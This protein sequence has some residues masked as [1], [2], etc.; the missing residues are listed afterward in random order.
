MQ[1]FESHKDEALSATSMS[2]QEPSL[3]GV[4]RARSGCRV[5][6]RL[7]GAAQELGARDS[8][9]LGSGT[10]LSSPANPAAQQ[11]SPELRVGSG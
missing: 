9:C 6:L 4:V 10:A 2:L 1:C 3:L 7:A 5:M 8:P 11:A